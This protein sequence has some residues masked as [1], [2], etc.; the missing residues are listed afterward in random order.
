MQLLPTVIFFLGVAC[1]SEVLKH[2]KKKGADDILLHP[3]VIKDFAIWTPA[4]EA[5]YQRKG[6]GRWAGW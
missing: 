4:V 6:V 2:P 3:E 1:P 5:R